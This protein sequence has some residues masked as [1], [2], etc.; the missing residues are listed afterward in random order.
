[1]I[2]VRKAEER[3]KQAFMEMEGEFCKH[4]RASGFNRHLKPVRCEDLPESYFVDSFNELL[5][6]DNFFLVAEDNG[7]VIG[8]IEAE[9]V[10]H[11]EKELYEIT[12]SGHIN[13]IFVLDKYRGRGVGARLMNEAIAWMKSK[14][15]QICTL[16]VV[17]GNDEAL[18]LY[19]KLGFRT[20]RTKMW[21]E[22]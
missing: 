16:G 14:G 11:Y 19:Q 13:S 18:A 12:K 5:S 21:K 3:D 4:Y 20:E 2:T 22:I 17:S 1:M 7:R 6:G 15:V 8:Y 9:I 10:E